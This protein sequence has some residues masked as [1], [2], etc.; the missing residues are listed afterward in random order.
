MAGQG[1]RLEAVRHYTIKTMHSVTTFACP[2]CK[3]SVTTLQF[4][5]DHGSR[6]TQAA[7]A[8]NEHAA[9][10]HCERR[11]TLQFYVPVCHDR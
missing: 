11:P 5:S 3:H 4:S 9:A 10:V 7:R 8:M 6:R 2:H 1:T